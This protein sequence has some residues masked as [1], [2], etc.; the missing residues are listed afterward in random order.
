[1]LDSLFIAATGMQAEQSQ[2]DTI[3]NNLVNMNTMGFKKSRVAFETLMS[4][5]GANVQPMGPLASAPPSYQGMGVSGTEALLDFTNGAL[6]Q[7][8][9]EFDLAIQG[10]GLF[11][12]QMPDGTTAYTRNG[13]FHV[14]NDR[15]LASADGYPLSGMLQIPNDA[16]KIVIDADG[17]VQ[18]KMQ[19]TDQL[20]DIG[21]LEISHFVD[22]SGLRP[23]GN[24]LYVATD[25]SGEAVNSRAG[26]N[27]AG[28]LAQGY[29]EGSNVQMIDEL[30]NMMTA[31]R[32]YEANSRV[33]QAS[34]EILGIINNLRK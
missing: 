23:V 4:Q 34:D 9:N 20:T 29:L 32:A 1:M 12:V 33:L 26:E 24:N 28:I 22:A 17:R 8:Q 3:S 6:K 19:N 7:T 11:E 30:T 18:A 31:Q 14:N 21:Y 10:D 16:E 15:Y 13:A 25:S 27:G 2:L 5:P